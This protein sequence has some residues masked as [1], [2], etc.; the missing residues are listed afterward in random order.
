LKGS[1]LYASNAGK[2]YRRDEFHS[3]PAAYHCLFYPYTRHT[4][5][6]MNG[7]YWDTD[8]PRLFE[9]EQLQEEGFCIQTIADITN[10]TEGSVPCNLGDS[11]IQEP[12]YGVDRKSFRRTAP[13]LPGSIDVMAVGNL[14]NELPRDASRYFGEQLLKY[15]FD[16]LISGGA[17]VIGRATMVK[18]GRITPP[19]SYLEEYGRLSPNAD[20]H[21]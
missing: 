7:T 4:D 18:K 3:N 21:S 12:V 17:D 16:A 5:I 9:K 15:V 20:P 14:P 2:T 19:F 11:T 10:D 1:A 13:Y 8:V 6:L